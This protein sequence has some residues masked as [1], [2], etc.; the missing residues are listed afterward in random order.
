MSFVSEDCSL[1]R[2]YKVPVSPRGY[3]FLEGMKSSKRGYIHKWITYNTFEEKLTKVPQKPASR[4]KH[5]GKEL[6]NK[7][8]CGN[9][10]IFDFKKHKLDP[11]L[12][13]YKYYRVHDNGGRPFLVYYHDNQALVYIKD[14]DKYYY[15]DETWNVSESKSRVMYTKL[16][17]KFKYEKIFVG[18][19]PLNDMTG[20][21]CGHG[22]RF[23]GNNLLFHIKGKK[24]I[25]IGWNIY[26]FTAG[27]KIDRFV[28]PV[29]NNDVPYPFAVGDKYVYLISDGKFVDKDNFDKNLV[30]VDKHTDLYSSWYGH[31]A[32]FN[33]SKK[34]SKQVKNYK[35]LHE[36]L[37]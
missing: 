3:R 31:E 33:S 9:K 25:S 15:D 12:K 10:E 22:K 7:H 8:Y 17:M 35:L 24:Y 20:F 32:G 1:F 13:K 27:D 29:G 37:W 21:S 34:E 5:F 26:S 2:I 4:L 11:K 6:I 18:K 30:D 14:E 16:V 23:D 19:S 36:R 28:S